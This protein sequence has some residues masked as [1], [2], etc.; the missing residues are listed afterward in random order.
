MR[1]RGLLLLLLGRREGGYD[2]YVEVYSRARG[3][4]VRNDEK[5]QFTNRLAFLIFLNKSRKR[6]STSLPLLLLSRGV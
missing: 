5:Q 3:L 4:R 2:C 1:D 6:R